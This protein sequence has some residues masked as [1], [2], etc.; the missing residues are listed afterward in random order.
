MPQII[1]DFTQDDVEQLTPAIKGYV[2]QIEVTLNGHFKL[3]VQ[4]A[5]KGMGR[6]VFEIDLDSEGVPGLFAPRH[7]VQNILGEYVNAWE[8]IYIDGRPLLVSMKPVGK[9][10]KGALWGTVKIVWS[11]LHS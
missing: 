6:A 10:K 4:D 1:M 11:D 7:Q 9:P 2:E 8:R 5:P 3:F